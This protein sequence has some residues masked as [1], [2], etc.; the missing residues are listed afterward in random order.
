MKKTTKQRF[1]DI[2]SFIAI[3]AILYGALGL[4]MWSYLQRI[5][6]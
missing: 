1:E 4:T 3:A 5:G 2:L 6:L